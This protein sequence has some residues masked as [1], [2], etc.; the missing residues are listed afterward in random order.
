METPHPDRTRHEGSSIRPPWTFTG[1]GANRFRRGTNRASWHPETR[2]EHRVYTAVALQRPYAMRKVGTV[3]RRRG[4][5]CR[6]NP[7]ACSPAARHGA[8]TVV[9]AATPMHRETHHAMAGCR[10]T[11]RLPWAD[12]CVARQG[13]KESTQMQADAREARRR[14]WV[15]N[16]RSRRKSHNRARGAVVTP[17]PTSHPRASRASACICVDSFLLALSR[18][19]PCRMGAQSPRASQNHSPIRASVG[20]HRSDDDT[21]CP[22]V[23]APAMPTKHRAPHP[24]SG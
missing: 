11:P 12:L 7:C 14:T 21:P 15:R 22:A 5:P 23:P 3:S 4:W 9:G 19:A 20:P 18:A 13:K 17:S 16:G 2:A 24:D 6:Q 1:G 10:A 8:R